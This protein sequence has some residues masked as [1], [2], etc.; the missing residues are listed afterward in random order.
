MLSY[1]FGAVAG[2]ENQLGIADKYQVTFSEK[3]R[4]ADTLSAARATMKF[5]T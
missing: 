5:A 1:A 2:A 4:V 3:I